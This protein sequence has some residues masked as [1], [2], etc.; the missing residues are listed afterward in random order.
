[1]QGTGRESPNED[2]CRRRR[3]IVEVYEFTVVAVQRHQDGIALPGQGYD[4]EIR[5]PRSDLGNF[6]NVVPLT[7]QQFS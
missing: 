7:A 4:I 2:D 5:A 1:M 6:D 3:R